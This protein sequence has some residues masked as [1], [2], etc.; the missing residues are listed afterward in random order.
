ML[1]VAPF[2]AEL[3]RRGLEGTIRDGD[4]VEP[5]APAA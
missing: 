5:L 3:A 4:A 2:F 1:P